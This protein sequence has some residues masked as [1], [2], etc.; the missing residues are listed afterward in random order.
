MLTQILIG[1][2][3]AVFVAGLANSSR[4]AMAGRGGFVVD[5]G[6]FGPAVADGEWWRIITSGFLHGGLLHVGMNMYLLY[7]LGGVLE[8]LIGRLRFGA[9]Y[10]TSLFTGSLG[11]LLIQPDALTVGASGAVFGLMG[12]LFL[13]YRERGLDPWSTGI[14]TTIV[15][16]LV[17]TFAIPGIS[18]GGHIGGLAGGLASAWMLF[19]GSRQIGAKAAVGAVFLLGAVAFV[20]CLLVA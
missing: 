17:F 2:N 16:N 12:A 19:E 20:A 10:F 14:G 18:I 11:V 15:I 8:P 1:I 3:A 13:A 6:L 9:V 5:G 4:N 7:L